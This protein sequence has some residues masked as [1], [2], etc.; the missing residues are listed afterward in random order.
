MKHFIYKTTHIN[1]RY[2]IGRH[3][4]DNLDD[5]YIGSG[6]WPMSIKDKSTLTREILEFVDDFE[7]LKEREAEHLAEH[8]G[9]PNCMNVNP[10]PV[11]FG[12]GN[13]NPMRN[14]KIA[15]K[16]SGENHWSNKDPNKFKEK[17]SGDNHWMSKNPDRKE[18][19]LDNH[20][21]KDGRNARLA[22]K[23]GKHN[24]ITNNPSTI[25]AANGTH[26]WQNGKSPNYQGKLN[27]KLISEGR[28]NFLGPET[29]QKRIDN[30]THNFLGADS[31]KKRLAMGTHPSQQKKTCIFCDKTVSIGMYKRW[32]GKN[33]KMK[34]GNGPS[35][36]YERMRDQQL[37]ETL[38]KAGIT[39]YKSVCLSGDQQEYEVILTNGTTVIVPSG[40][41]Y[42]CD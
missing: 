35:H 24:S 28:H 42:H 38:E 25:N 12:E 6:T 21:N 4:T 27:D 1:G 41:P 20:P 34:Q 14:P 40:L 19:F 3:S 2:Y 33:C 36:R 26:H 39:D 5:G 11:G 30:G 17:F 37:K 23:R 18:E 7:T 15:A 13:H 10:D 8:I 9:K 16:I 32:H 31:N 22:Y 29:N